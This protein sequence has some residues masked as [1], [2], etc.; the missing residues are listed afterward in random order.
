MH[1]HIWGQPSVFLF[2]GLGIA[3]GIAGC[4]GLARRDGFS[5]RQAL[6]LAISIGFIFLLGTKIHAWFADPRPFLSRG[7]YTTMMVGFHFPG[8]VILTGLTAPFLFRF[9]R[10]PALRFLDTI[11]PMLGFSIA[12]ARIGCFLN[13]CCFGVACAYP[14]G[15]RFPRGSS[16]FRYNALAGQLEPDRLTTIP[17]HPLQLYFSLAGLA[18]GL[19]LLWMRKRRRFEGEL[20]LWGLVFWAWSKV[21]I[22]SLRDP[23]LMPVTPHLFETGIAIAIISSLGLIA[24]Y[25]RNRTVPA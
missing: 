25:W 7:W 6:P 20:V 11:V 8:G 13:G 12:I 23:A 10:V 19:F 3:V 9:F 5:I 1:T 14:W 21:A 4:V 18:L 22:E 2:W 16:A 24:S 15:M 17:L